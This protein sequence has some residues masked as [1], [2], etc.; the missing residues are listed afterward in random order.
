Q[1]RIL[2]AFA[3]HEIDF[4]S[5]SHLTGQSASLFVQ[6]FGPDG[7][8]DPGFATDGANPVTGNAA[9]LYNASGDGGYATP[10]SLMTGAAVTRPDGKIAVLMRD[11]DNADAAPT[12]ALL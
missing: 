9:T 1:G 3:S 6:R 5:D 11:A 2:I 8:A 10:I 4:D 12:L 7:T